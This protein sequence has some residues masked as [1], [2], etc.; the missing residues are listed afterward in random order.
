MPHP[1]RNQ[2]GAIRQARGISVAELARRVGLSRQTIYAIES[3]TYVPNTVVS[4]LLARE[5]EVAVEEVFRLPAS[6]ERHETRL[7]VELLHPH[8]SKAGAPVRLCQVG[9]HTVAFP[10]EAAPCY[11]AESDAV[12][13]K[14]GRQH[15]AEIQ[16][17]ADPAGKRL[18]LAG[19]DPAIGLLAAELWRES[20][21]ELVT[22]A[23]SSR[24][25]L[26]WFKE[27]KVHVAGTHLR[28]PQSGE[29]NLPLL[30]REL[31]GED[32]MV[33][34]FAHWEEGLVTAPG[35]PLGIR[36]G[37]DLAKRGVRFINREEGSGSRALFD[38]LLQREGLTVRRIAGADRLARGHLAA[39]Y[40]V[41][42]GEADCC[43]ATRSAAQAFRL[44]FV[45]LDQERFDFVLRR[46]DLSLPAI[47][48]FLQVLQRASLRR[49]LEYQAGC[50]TRQT[51][52]ILA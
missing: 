43:I 12:L 13:A 27:G 51:G 15:F 22:A 42:N 26:R 7:R 34:T 48:A 10:V 35:N 41:L 39:A 4:L 49:R 47:Q 19:C 14:E 33:V 18:A 16:S 2:L 37:G 5:L 25:A 38:R 20:G 45:P 24:Q 50:E 23:A 9:S 8:A 32:V 11:L 52:A 30:R 40:A 3:G 21:V 28:D 44:G 31:A 6:E 29:F 17:F 36:R 46:Q 1:I